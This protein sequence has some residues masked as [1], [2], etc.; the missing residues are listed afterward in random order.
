MRPARILAFDCTVDRFS[1]LL[2]EGAEVRAERVRAA[3]TWR[4]EQV[5]GELAA[6]LAGAG[7]DWRDL[8]LLAVA[9]GPGSFTGVRTAVAVARALAL[10]ADRPVLAVS[11]LE[12]IAATARARHG[13]ADFH[14]ALAAGRG[15]V[16]LLP[17]VAGAPAETPVTVPATEPRRMLPAGSVLAGARLERIADALADALRL[18]PVAPDARG[19]WAAARARLS[20]GARPRPGH[21]VRPLYLR[22]P[23]ADPAAG[24]PLVPQPA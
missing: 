1:V 3:G 17:V 5:V 14:A 15:L 13:L 12:A 19:V 6:L 8:D 23:A 7:C 10:A 22:G 9:V 18:L 21:E 20:R 24:R 16:H 2:A 11:T 4:G